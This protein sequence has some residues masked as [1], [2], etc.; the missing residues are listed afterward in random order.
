MGAFQHC[1]FENQN[2]RTFKWY[3]KIP[4]AEIFE[5]INYYSFPA[6]NGSRSSDVTQQGLV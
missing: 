4:L 2:S 6:V 1:Y 3:I 5:F